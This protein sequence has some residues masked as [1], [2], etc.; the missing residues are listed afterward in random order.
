M[1]NGWLF[2]Q[3]DNSSDGPKIAIFGEK[4]DSEGNFA[5]FSQAGTVAHEVCHHMTFPRNFSAGL[6]HIFMLP[7]ELWNRMFNRFPRWEIDSA[8]TSVDNFKLLNMN[9]DTSSVAR[10]YS[11]QQLWRR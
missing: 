6:K 4:K 7:A 1:G 5:V 8:K 9:V 3:Y 11:E 10:A 2:G